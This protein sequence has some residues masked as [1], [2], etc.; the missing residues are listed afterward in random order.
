MKKFLRPTF[1]LLLKEISKVIKYRFLEREFLKL[2][3][4]SLL[5]SKNVDFSDTL[6]TYSHSPK[7]FFFVRPSKTKILRDTFRTLNVYILL[8]LNASVHYYLHFLKRRFFPI[9]LTFQRRDF[10]K[11][12]YGK[13]RS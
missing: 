4:R 10:L 2:N 3:F 11:N 9:S 13:F 1:T 12:F 5:K 6:G 7:I 8:I